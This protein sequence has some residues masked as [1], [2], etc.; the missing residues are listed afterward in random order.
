MVVYH[1]SYTGL[2][3]MKDFFVEE[4]YAELPVGF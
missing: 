4:T 2:G 1:S 3:R